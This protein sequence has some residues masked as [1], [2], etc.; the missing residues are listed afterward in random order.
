MNRKSWIVA[1]IGIATLLGLIIGSLVLLTYEPAQDSNVSPSPSIGI[2]N[3][4]T[5]GSTDKDDVEHK[6]DRDKA[7]QGKPIRTEEDM[8]RLDALVI[9][10]LSGLDFDGLS[11]IVMS[12]ANAYQTD[13][14]IQGLKIDI[15][16]TLNATEETAPILLMTYNTP[17]VLAAAVASMP[18]S[19]KL[20]SFLSADSLMLPAQTGNIELTKAG[21][22]N[23]AMTAMLERAN[24]N[25]TS[26]D[27]CSEV[28]AYDM[29][30]NG[31]PCRLWMVKTPNG[32][33]PYLL[34]Q[35]YNYTTGTLTQLEVKKIQASLYSTDASLDDV[36]YMPLFD[37]AA[38]LA[39]MD[40]HPEN[41]NPDRSMKL[42]NTEPDTGMLESE[43]AQSPELGQTQQPD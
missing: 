6:E 28:D 18:V 19:Y 7:E 39:D 22:D 21:V 36:I 41:Y 3:P 15:A 30:L 23:E 32:W 13:A 29:R 10:R 2:L 24:V 34:E 5:L 35:K 4:D 31:L 26:L 8:E 40:A 43:Q 14:Y 1:G 42:I 25:T 17:E 33:Q 20:D 27:R 37:E 11:S 12:D 16:N 9:S 38:Y